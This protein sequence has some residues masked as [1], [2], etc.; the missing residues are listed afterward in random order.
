M[1]SANRK[2]N[3]VLVGLVSLNLI[4]GGLLFFARATTSAETTA[5][6]QPRESSRRLRAKIVAQQRAL[7]A[8]HERLTAA[9]AAARPA[10][11]APPERRQFTPMDF[12]GYYYADPGTRPLVTDFFRAQQAAS[13]RSLFSQLHLPPAE[14]EALRTFL[15][16]YK[17]RETENTFHHFLAKDQKQVDAQQAA[18][19][20]LAELQAEL[21]RQLERL[22]P[23][24][25]AGLVAGLVANPFIADQLQML[26]VDL[27]RQ[28]APLSAGQFFAIAAQRLAPAPAPEV[29][30]NLTDVE[31]I[32][33]TRRETEARLVSQ[34]AAQLTP[35]Q[36]AALSAR[37]HEED[38]VTLGYLLAEIPRPTPKTS[39]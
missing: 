5:S 21:P 37:L 1:M 27:R 13:F 24:D 6:D 31:R 32:L 22:L 7:R 3:I 38:A 28:Q 15:A 25:Q 19:M 9:R 34:L 16:D 14:E 17:A 20:Q 35:V 36:T 2:K 11:P 10:A 23:G 33:H 29:P 12:V 8:E 4:L 18:D 39:P 30:Q 26:D